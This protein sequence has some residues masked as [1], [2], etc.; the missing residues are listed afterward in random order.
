[1][2]NRALPPT[3]IVELMK[4]IQDT[5]SPTRTGSMDTARLD[6]WSQHRVVLPGGDGVDRPM[7]GAERALRYSTGG[8]ASM[9]R[10]N[11]T[12]TAEDPGYRGRARR[13]RWR[14]RADS[15]TGGGE[16]I[17]RHG[18]VDLRAY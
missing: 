3:N 17:R 18:Y 1:M 8:R 10:A 7:H 16:W 13:H 5:T 9:D 4:A 6:S 14:L 12:S 2:L 11:S 15:S